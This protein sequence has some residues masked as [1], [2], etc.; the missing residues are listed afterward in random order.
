MRSHENAQAEALNPSVD[1]LGSCN[2]PSI[3]E[4]Q[5]IT[6][7]TPISPLLAFTHFLGLCVILWHFLRFVKPLP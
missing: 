2:M 5:F 1:S 4:T 6:D 7:L 3:T